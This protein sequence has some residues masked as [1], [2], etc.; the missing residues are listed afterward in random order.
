MRDYGHA[1]SAVEGREERGDARKGCSRAFR[2]RNNTFVIHTIYE[3]DES[4]PKND[5]S[6]MYTP[7]CTCIYDYTRVKGAGYYTHTLTLSGTEARRRIVLFAFFSRA[8]FTAYTRGLYVDKQLAL[9]HKP[10]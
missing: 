9:S 7:N 5:R 3:M 10:R 1:Q 6:S 8:R 4:V 2:F